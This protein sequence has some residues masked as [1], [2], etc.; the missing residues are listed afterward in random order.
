MGN[1]NV[2]CFHRH[3]GSFPFPCLF[4]L[5]THA[6][7]NMTPSTTHKFNDGSF[8]EKREVSYTVEGSTCNLALARCVY[9]DGSVDLL[10]FLIHDS[11]IC[12]NS[13]EMLYLQIYKTNTG[14]LH[15]IDFKS[16][17]SSIPW[18]KTKKTVHPY[19][20][21]TDTKV[22]L[23]ASANRSGLLIWKCKKT[24]YHEDAKEVTM[25]HYFVNGN[26]TTVVNRSIETTNVG[27]SVLV[28]VGV[29]DGKFDII[30]EG[31]E[32]HPV[33]ALL[34]MF[35]QVN[36]SGIWKPSMCPDCGKHS[37]VSWQSDFEDNDGVPLSPPQGSRQNAVTIVN[38]GRFRGHAPGA[39]I[40][41]M[42]FNAYN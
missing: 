39:S 34:Y 16:N 23:Y 5:G 28:K 12:S 37:R 19:G 30:S 18:T 21:V 1:N 32:Q 24:A 20:D 35:N 2:A 7:I 13:M 27:F 3:R 36:E 42:N 4:Q 33:S 6:T 8:S 22:Y 40:R 15:M 41:C 31:P 38:D 26:G 9:R 10:T 14:F 29:C 11:I 25:A 17:G